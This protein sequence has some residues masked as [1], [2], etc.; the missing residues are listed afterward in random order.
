[1]PSLRARVLRRVP[2]MLESFAERAAELL[3]DRNHAVV[4]AGMTLMLDICTTH[5]SAVEAYRPQVP[6]LCKIL[7]S[8]IM[9]SN[10]P[11]DGVGLGTEH[12]CCW[13]GGRGK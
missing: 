1:M 13:H 3:S 2:D 10:A 12:A 7:R 4:L 8:L 11:G 5:P 6:Q 9:S